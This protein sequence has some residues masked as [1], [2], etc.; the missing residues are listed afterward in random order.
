MTANDTNTS[1]RML[2]A[3]HNAQLQF[4]VGRNYRAV[5]YYCTFLFQRQAFFSSRKTKQKTNDTITFQISIATSNKI[6]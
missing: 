6:T 1:T 3:K 5:L 2:P 4:I